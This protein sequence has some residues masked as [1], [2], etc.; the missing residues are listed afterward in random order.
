VHAQDS[1]A[2]LMSHQLVLI[3]KNQNLQ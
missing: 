3:N 2:M 1:S